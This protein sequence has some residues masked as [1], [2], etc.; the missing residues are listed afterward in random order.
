MS[1][2][3]VRLFLGVSEITLA[4]DK[5]PRQSSWKKRHF[6]PPAAPSYCKLHLAL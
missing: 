6:L 2:V 4:E 1:P 5:F 3:G